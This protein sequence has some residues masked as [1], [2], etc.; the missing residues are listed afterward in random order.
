[1]QHFVAELTSWTKLCHENILELYGVYDHAPYGFAMVSPWMEHGHILQYLESHPDVPRLP[2]LLDVAVGLNYLHSL[3]PSPIIHGDLRGQNILVR[4]SGQACLADFGLSRSLAE[5]QTDD[6]S[7]SSGFWATC[8]N[9]RYM[10]PERLLP[11]D[12]GLTAL[13]SF[14][15]AADVWSFGMVLLAL[16]SGRRPF[17]LLPDDCSLLRAII[18]RER[19]QH[20]GSLAN[21]RGLC[22]ALWQLAQDC[23]KEERT[24]R[25]TASDI[26]TRI[27]LRGSITSAT[28]SLAPSLSAYLPDNGPGE[29]IVVHGIN[30]SGDR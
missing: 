5:I 2:L 28:L 4:S 12:H 18:Q 7:E 20:P 3:L 30:D 17:H 23:W 13:T 10:S 9:P 15:P 29:V 6:S 8:G 22:D 21:Q 1:L 14:T 19:P 11:D 27:K 16:F 25:P 24:E 26:V